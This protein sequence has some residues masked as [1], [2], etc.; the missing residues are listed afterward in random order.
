ML[1]SVVPHDY[2]TGHKLNCFL[3]DGDD[4]ERLFLVGVLN[5]FVIEW[6]IR[7][8]ARSNHIKKFMLVQIP[9]PRPPR[10]A[11]ERIAALVATLVTAD[12]RFQ[13]LRPLL[14]GHKPVHEPNDRHEIKC[15]IDAEVARLFDLNRSELDRVLS[16][17]DKVPEGTKRR[18]RELFSS[19]ASAT[20]QNKALASEA[21][22]LI[23]AHRDEYPRLRP[24]EVLL[25][26]A[27]LQQTTDVEAGDLALVEIV[28]GFEQEPGMAAPP[29]ASWPSTLSSTLLPRLRFFV[30]GL[31]D[32]GHGSLAC[33]RVREELRG[34]EIVDSQEWIDPEDDPLLP[35][36]LEI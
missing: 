36:V 3:V 27:V 11:V 35:Q 15:Q 1:C 6:R 16:V 26:A 10:A 34:W 7:Q 21:R 20:S 8:L 19:E 18:V 5:S 4:A 14:K 13:D 32:L 23:A 22:R 33:Q 30:L 2:A 9:A 29:V 24:G 25:A 28:R 31:A 12:E 17:Y